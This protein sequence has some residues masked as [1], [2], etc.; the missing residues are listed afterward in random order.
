MVLRRYFVFGFFLSFVFRLSAQP[1]TVHASNIIISNVYCHSFDVTWTSGNGQKRVVFAGENAPVKTTNI[2]NSAFVADDSFGGGFNL[3]IGV[4]AVYNGTGNSFK[5]RNLKNNTTYF[6]AIFEYNINSG[7]YEYYTASGYATG[8]QLTENISPN[9]TI[10]DTYQC[11]ADNSYSF[12][13]S[14]SNSR[15]ESMMYNWD[16][17]DSTIDTTTNTAHVYSKGGIFKVAL[18]ASSPGCKAAI[19]K[20]DTVCVPFI[21]YF[22]LDNTIPGNDSVQ[23]FTGNRFQLLNKFK[24]PPPIYGT[25]DRAKF[26]WSTSQGHKGSSLNF[27]FTASQYGKITV[28]LIQSRQV[29]KGGEFCADSFQRD[30]YLLPPPLKDVD[31][32]FSDTVL[33]LNQGA[34]TFS[35]NGNHITNT[36]WIFDDGDTSHKNPVTHSY[37]SMG[38]YKVQLKVIDSMGCEDTLSKEVEVI[39]LG[40]AKMQSVK[41]SIYP[42]PAAEFIRI[43]SANSWEQS[44]SYLLRIF[45]ASGAL[46]S[47]SE[48]SDLSHPVSINHLTKGM[49]VLQ[50]ISDGVSGYTQFAVVGE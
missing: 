35:H 36:T 7:V 30:F 10:D 5:L 28:K 11:L 22:E 4:Y 9:F 39:V 37:S 43:E 29:S 17:G 50:L 32:N 3:N 19:T 24:Y 2:Y 20:Q 12:T 18:T 49:Y 23:C 21:T 34:F 26:S 38:K 45:S 42:N 13:N 41:L 1:P 40:I 14:S 6:L 15:G 48:T 44:S 25:W 46:I 31:V 8:S 16:F 27:D 33:Y 47:E